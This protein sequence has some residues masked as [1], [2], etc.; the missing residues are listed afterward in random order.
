MRRRNKVNKTKSFKV[1]ALVFFALSVALSIAIPVVTAYP[2][3]TVRSCNIDGELTEEFGP[4]EIVC[5]CGEGYER[6][7]AVTIYVV[8]NNYPHHEEFSLCSADAEADSSGRLDPTPLCTACVELPVGEYDM[9]VDRD[10]SG[11]MSYAFEPSWYWCARAGFLVIPE[12]WLGTILGLIGCFAAFGV[13]R[14][15]KNRHQ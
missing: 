14:A 10:G 7:E 6:F 12:Y 11:W 8:P 4:G 5:A 2:S 9:W 15:S 13:F 1:W 3:A